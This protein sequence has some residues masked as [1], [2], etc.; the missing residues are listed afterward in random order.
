[1]K[2]AHWEPV[3][4][5]RRDVVDRGQYLHVRYQGIDYRDD[6]YGDLDALMGQRD[7]YGV[8][9]PGVQINGI[10][11]AISA[12]VARRY[13]RQTDNLGPWAL[14]GLPAS[15]KD[16]MAI[17]WMWFEHRR[18]LLLGNTGVVC[19][20]GDLIML[21]AIAE[22][23][24]VAGIEVA[25]S[26]DSCSELFKHDGRFTLHDR[27]LEPSAA[28]VHWARWDFYPDLRRLV[29]HVVDY[30]QQR[31]EP[32]VPTTR[33]RPELQVPD[34]V[35]ARVCERISTELGAR[36]FAVITEKPEPDVRG[37]LPA[38]FARALQYVRPL[39]HLGRDPAHTLPCDLDLGGRLELLESVAAVKAARFAIT[40][41]CWLHHAA[42]AVGTR[43]IFLD[44]QT[45]A[46]SHIL[47]P[48]DGGYAGDHLVTTRSRPECHPCGEMK[49]CPAGTHACRDLEEVAI[50]RA[51][52]STIGGIDRPACSSAT[53]HPR[54]TP[55]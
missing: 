26:L 49:R 28:F 41:D 4:P 31:L 18:R 54:S 29:H 7:R 37:P 39:V 1:M 10:L 48:P 8:P 33:I 32:I 27:G 47:Y 17:P 5:V 14:W 40:A 19:G 42:A 2:P 15:I 55:A 50:A 52:A 44:T 51:V 53:A 20:V 3:W 22:N 23:F 16:A 12:D 34:D 36:D 21:A 9:R 13:R 43:C 25:L 24:R 6:L 46:T 11:H 35:L 38:Q 30:V 45:R